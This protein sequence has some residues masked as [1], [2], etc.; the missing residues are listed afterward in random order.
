MENV[1][2]DCIVRPMVFAD[3]EQ[4]LRLYRQLDDWHA[5]RYPGQFK[6]LD[7]TASSAFS[8]QR[9]ERCPD[10]LVAEC[11]DVVVGFVQLYLR[12]TGGIPVEN[13]LEYAQVDNFVVDEAHRGMGIGLA[14]LN[15]ARDWA[16]ARGINGLRVGV[17]SSNT[18]AVE[19][20]KKAGF[21]PLTTLLEMKIG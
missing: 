7:D 8:L 14:L 21:E 6:L 1:G 13:P 15:A 18:P 4:V 11:V 12:K 5:L 16:K 17:F 20:Y 19:L 10:I 9:I 2:A 3:M